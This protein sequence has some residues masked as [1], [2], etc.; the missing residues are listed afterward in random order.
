MVRRL[1]IAGPSYEL[2]M[3]DTELV[4]VGDVCDRGVNSRAIYEVIMAWQASA[5]SQGSRV[6]FLLGNHEAM[7]AFGFRDY[8][9]VEE[10]L[11]FDPASAAAGERA[12]AEA[13]S[14]GGWLFRWLCRQRAI[15]R[16][17][18]LV[19]SHG[20]LPLALREWTIE[21]ID[22]RVMA[23]FR[24]ARADDTRLPDPLFAPETSILWCRQAQFERPEGYGEALSAFLRRNGASAFV[25]GHTPAEE[26]L[27]R[28]GY[29]GR[30]L[31]IDTAMT[32]ERQG[33]GRKS[34]L[35]VEGN[36]ALAL[37]LDGGEPVRREVALDL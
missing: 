8:N 34:A 19:F 26:G 28:L 3:P 31:C 36:K 29:G 11:A 22:D 7:N 20:D 25:C 9:T 30:Y 21:E 1:G 32:F 27:F 4:F 15:V 6:S 13:F 2:D 12:H 17:G 23:A 24:G 5:P 18:P 14:P 16:V 37:Y 33:I 10:Y 35:I